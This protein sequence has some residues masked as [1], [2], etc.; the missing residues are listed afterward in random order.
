MN[1]NTELH[2]AKQ[3]GVNIKRSTFD[4]SHTHK[5]TFNTGELVPIYVEEI[6][7]GDT[8]KINTNY[9]IR[10]STPIKPVMDNA[11]MDI[12]FFFVPNRLVWDHWKEFMGEN[13][14]GAWDD[15]ETEYNV[16]K[17]ISQIMSSYKKG[18]IADHMGI[19]TNT[20][21]EV[22][23]LPFRA[24]TLIWNEWFRDQNLQA[25]LYIQKDIDSNQSLSSAGDFNPALGVGI[26]KVNKFHDYL[27]SCL[28]EP[29]KG[30][31]V[32]INIGGEAPV[33]TS[34][35]DNYN[36]ESPTIGMKYAISN[37]PEINAK[38]I[39]LGL[40]NQAE[41][42][43][44]VYD[45]KANGIDNG[46]ASP[47]P[48]I[49]APSN[50]IADLSNAT[51]VTINQ[52]RQAVQTQKFLERDAR[53]GTRYIEIIKGHFGVTSPDARQQRPEYL[54]GKRVPINMAQVLQTSA[55]QEDSPQ[56]NTAAF[57]LT[58]GSNAGFTKSFTEHGF[59]IG[60]ACVRTQHSYQ[61]GLNRMWSRARRFDY[62]WPEFSHLGEQAVL[63]KEI[64]TIIDPNVDPEDVFGYQE[65]YAEYKYKPN[66]ITGEF[67]SQYTQSLDI[68]HYGDNYE[69]QPYLSE[70]WI[71]E[72]TANVDR[73]LTVQSTNSDQFL[74]DFYFQIKA[75][76]PMPLFGIP[77]LMD[78]F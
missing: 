23:V 33:L 53:C 25:P 15:D 7:P 51:A 63:N 3:P 66:I 73:T 61:Q 4:L 69:S 64:Y 12:Y 56:G 34:E 45:L 18:S 30:D 27:T 20:N 29:Q 62:Y 54:G 8:F 77:G 40:Y 13:T 65:R 22:N 58:G 75:T 41:G 50:L 71:Q 10:M 49:I 42:V 14:E 19:P 38:H 68:W 24:Y 5:T 1:R 16:P 39:G 32:T 59:I 72:T 47:S 70:E 43:K 35:I 21:L 17:A 31:P 57:S 37:N 28:P 74:A 78:H 52:L 11:Y 76:R 36:G 26:C 46:T 55:S 67:R 6:L 60:L 44:R 2:F 48:E 9:V